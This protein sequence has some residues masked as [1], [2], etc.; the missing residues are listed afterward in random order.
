LSLARLLPDSA[1]LV[2]RDGLVLKGSGERIYMLQNEQLRWISSMDAFEHLDL[3]WDD[4]HQVD[5][6]FLER[7]EMGRPLDILLKCEGRDP[8]YVLRDGEKHWIRDI[9]VFVA[10]GY[11]WEDVT[12]VSCPYLRSLPDGESIPPDAGTP[13]QP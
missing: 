4:V 2:I 6:A 10:E 8:I 12:F 11:V 7:F 9:E 1:S 5:D 13:P 3:S